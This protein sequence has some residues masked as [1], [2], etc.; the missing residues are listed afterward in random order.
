MLI[1]EI[2][3]ELLSPPKSQN[4]LSIIVGE[5][6][7]GKSTLLS[8]LST[9]F[10][11]RGKDVI[12]IANT[13]HDKFDVNHINFKKLRGRSGRRMSRI[14]IK[15]ALENV[16][17]S[18]NI[19]FKNAARALEYV[20]F[21]K[22]IGLKLDNF[23]SNFDSIL[24]QSFFD[25][26]ARSE[27]ISLLYK[28]N[29][30]SKAEEIIWLSL[31]EFNFYDFE[32]VSL[33]KLLFWE[34]A[35]KSLKVISRIEIFLRKK[36]QVVSMLE[37]SS[38]EITL[39]TSIIYIA[40]AITDNTVILIDEPENSLHPKWQKEYAKTILDLFYLYQPKII[41]ATHSP[42][43]V[44]G[45][46]LFVKDSN[47]YKGVGFKFILQ[48]NEPLNVEELL[49]SFFDINTPQSHYLSERLVRLVNLV[50]NNKLSIDL[51][52]KEI[53]RLIQYSYDPKQIQ[54]L[55]SMKALASDISTQS[56]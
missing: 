23:V 10:L 9:Q 42:I 26:M 34:K 13:I 33:L 45:A 5:N 39:I 47:I 36:G 7:A 38:G 1:Q 21:E 18:E 28:V 24:T 11:N 44:N 52:D 8:E 32:R 19:K 40:T 17:E 41:I 12:A 48:S 25:E 20:N 37:A 53:E 43:I 56:N 46:E 50:A 14:T 29:T 15:K 4:D 27:I 51:F 31:E 6:G 16:A 55:N 2:P 35:L 54:V 22:V 3:Q 49:F 30:E